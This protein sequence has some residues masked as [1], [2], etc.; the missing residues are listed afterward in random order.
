MR[1]EKTIYEQITKNPK[2]IK[3]CPSCATYES[4]GAGTRYQCMLLDLLKEKSELGI[5]VPVSSSHPCSWEE[6][7]GCKVRNGVGSI[8][9]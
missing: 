5:I 1:K 4:H 3:R 9:G 8:S 7:Q 2:L 6:A